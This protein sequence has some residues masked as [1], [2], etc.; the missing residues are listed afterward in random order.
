VTAGEPWYRKFFERDYYDTFY[1]PLREGAGAL[2]LTPQA[3]E[4]QAAFIAEALALPPGARVLD[5]CCGHG[6]HSVA[7]AQRG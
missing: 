3:S 2:P 6:R 5:L 7:L 4:Q 1:A